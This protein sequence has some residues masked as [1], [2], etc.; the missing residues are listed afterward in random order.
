MIVVNSLQVSCTKALPARIVAG[1]FPP[2][3]PAEGAGAQS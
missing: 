2:E 3:S 1:V